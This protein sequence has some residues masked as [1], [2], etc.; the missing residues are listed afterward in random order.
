SFLEYATGLSGADYAASHERRLNWSAAFADTFADCDAFA[1]PSSFMPPPPADALDP[2]G[3]FSDAIAPFMRFTA[4]FNFSGSPTL[5]IPCGFTD[6]GLPQ[7]LQLVAAH[8]AEAML[9]R[10]GDVYERSTEWH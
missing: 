8:G 7:S 9:C 1:C 10:V 6:D 3:E 2:Y 5:S 4:P